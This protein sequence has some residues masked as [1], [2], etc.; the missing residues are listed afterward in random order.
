MRNLFSLCFTEILLLIHR[1]LFNSISEIMQPGGCWR[2]ELI[3]F[4]ETS[5]DSRHSHGHWCSNHW[6]SVSCSVASRCFSW[7]LVPHLTFAAALFSHRGQPLVAKSNCVWW[8][9]SLTRWNAAFKDNICRVTSWKGFC[10]H[11]AVTSSPA[12]LTTSGRRKRWGLS[13][14]TAVFVNISLAALAASPVHYLCR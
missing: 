11:L 13:P 8:P 12:S 9:S 5:F 2:S 14:S 1:F 4:V 7:C 10:G 6:V 3:A